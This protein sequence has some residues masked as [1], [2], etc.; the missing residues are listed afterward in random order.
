L[1]YDEESREFFISDTGKGLQAQDL[2]EIYNFHTYASSKRWIRQVSRGSLGNALKTVIGICFLKNYSLEWRFKEGFCFSC[3]L[4]EVQKNRGTLFFETTRRAYEGPW[5]IAIRGFLIDFELEAKLLAF[6]WANPDITFH[7]NQK[8]FTRF[9]PALKRETAPFLS[10]YDFESFH[11]LATR[12]MQKEPHLRVRTF[13]KSFRGVSAL[14]DLWRTLAPWADESLKDLV[15]EKE[16]L[17]T[18]YLTLLQKLPPVSPKVLKIFLPSR[19]VYKAYLNPL[20]FQEKQGVFAVHEAKIPFLLQGFLVRSSPEEA[21]RLLSVVNG[22]VP[23]EDDPFVFSEKEV[24]FLGFEAQTLRQKSYVYAGYQSI[25]EVLQHLHFFNGNG[26]ILFVH[27]ISPLIEFSDHAKTQ[28]SASGF[29]KELEALV[30]YVAT[31]LLKEIR[32]EELGYTFPLF[33]GEKGHKK[34]LMAHHFLEAFERA[35]GGY[36]VFV[37]QVF[38]KLHEILNHQYGLDLTTSDYHTLTQHIAT[39]MILKEAEV[40]RRLLFSVRGSFTHSFSKQEIPLG[41]KEIQD[42]LSRKPRNQILHEHRIFY[43]YEDRYLLKNVLFIEKVGFN[44]AL[45]ESG[46][47]Q[48]LNLSIMSTQGN[49][50]RAGAQF[51]RYCK[52]QGLKL[53]SLT[54]YDLAGLKIHQSIVQASPTY[55]AIPEVR[56]I[57]LSL[58]EVESLHL[59]PEV[60]FYKNNYR[61]SNFFQEL[62]LE[63]QC[64]FTKDLELTSKKLQRVEL[65]ALSN[66]QLFELLRQSIQETQVYPPED[67]LW[68][69]LEMDEEYLKKSVLYQRFVKLFENGEVA[70]DKKIFFEK[71]KKSSRHWL[72][73]L[74]QIKAEYE[75]AIMQKMHAHLEKLERLEKL[76]EF[77][78]LHQK[79]S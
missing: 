24:C 77:L 41:T 49:N 6:H 16:S 75:Y 39:Q 76:P 71:F 13:L 68:K 47:T 19:N 58:E 51:L 74:P 18:V 45:E 14:K 66:Q 79:K 64:F 61:E 22:S 42:Y 34:T 56:R 40:A 27:L 55:P 10:W 15:D 62:P 54:D 52:E 72:E 8:T 7:W 9:A 59:F 29:K 2:E 20:R 32:R 60:V 3:V 38:Y 23:Y 65:N 53:Y 30:E 1:T 70:V 33:L 31:P 44:I 73:E 43:D 67:I 69:A 48:E 12:T 57:G 11:L 63:D 4:N 26:F 28:I 36:S 5:G 37:R 50:T 25:K 46:L 21:N 78:S 35:S 17:K